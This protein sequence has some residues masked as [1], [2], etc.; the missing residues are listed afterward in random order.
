VKVQFVVRSDHAAKFGGDRLQVERYAD[1]LALLGVQVAVIPYSPSLSL[2]P[3][4]VTHIV[5]IDRP[6]DFLSAVRQSP[7]PFVVSPIHHELTRVRAMRRAEPMGGVRTVAGWLPE[8]ARELLAYGVRSYRGGHRR[9]L[10]REGLRAASTMPRVWRHVGR[11]LDR[12]AAVAVLAQGEAQVLVRDTG[13]AGRNAVVIPN[14]RPVLPVTD[15]PRGWPERDRGILV[16]GR[17]EP[18]KRQVEIGRVAAEV[19]ASVVFVGPLSSSSRGYA[20]DF[21][22]LVDSAPSLEWAG[23]E[24]HEEVLRRMARHRVLLNMSWVEVQS[25]VDLEAAFSGCFVVAS[26]T[27]HSAEWMPDH[28]RVFEPSDV[29]PAIAEA[30]RLSESVTGPPR[31]EYGQ[32][33]ERAAQQLLDVYRG[34]SSADGSPSASKGN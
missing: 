6:Y 5:N 24:P 10:A 7:G 23:E 9:G 33:W 28:V 16:V 20:D 22:S 29:A 31:L 3:D 27:G 25:L 13:W 12:A 19:G 14:G 18:R 1:D 32:T 8:N 34:H 21:L 26:G 15:S 30:T 4:A 17:I 2:D 11:A